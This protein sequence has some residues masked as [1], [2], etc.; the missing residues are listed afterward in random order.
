[1]IKVVLICE[2]YLAE[3][4][5]LFVTELIVCINSKTNRKTL[6]CCLDSAVAQYEQTAP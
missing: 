5:F 6:Y 1:M 2:G 4:C 3:Q